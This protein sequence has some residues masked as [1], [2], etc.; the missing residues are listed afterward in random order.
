MAA[1]PELDEAPLADRVEWAT[2]SILTTAGRLDEHAFLERIYALFPGMEA[3]D[4]ELVRACLSAYAIGRGE[5]V[6]RTEED[7]GRAAAGPRPR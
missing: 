5:G 3:P 4:E 6:L 7:A 2:F 1:Q